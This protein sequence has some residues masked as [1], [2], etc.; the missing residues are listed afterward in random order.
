MKKL[1]ALVLSAVLLMAL[2]PTAYAAE[3]GYTPA[4]QTAYAKF[5]IAKSIVFCIKM[6]AGLHMSKKSSTFAGAKVKY[7]NNNDKTRTH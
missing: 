4:P 6:R 5:F 3:A 7:L 2:I 1:V